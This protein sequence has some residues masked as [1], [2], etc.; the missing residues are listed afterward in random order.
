M[1]PPVR[2]RPGS[3]PERAFPA[4][5]R[6]EPV[7]AEFDER[8]VHMNRLMDGA[9]TTPAALSWSST[10]DMRKTDSAHVIEAELPGV[11][12]GD[13]AIEMSE[14]ELRITGK[15]KARG[16]ESVL[17]LRTRRTGHFEYQALL[18]AGVTTDEVSATLGDGVLTVT[19]PKAQATRAAAHRNHPCRAR[20][21]TSRCRRKVVEPSAL[22]S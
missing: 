21:G 5:G 18:P 6:G 3:L 9:A 13:I 22:L 20:S 14:R 15:C 8:F 1:T 2:H 19:V 11:K 16:H 4:F 17:R 10:A 12:R 7:A